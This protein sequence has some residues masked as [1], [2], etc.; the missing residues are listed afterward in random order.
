MKD[1]ILP[2][3]SVLMIT[4]NHAP[5]IAQALDSILAQERDFDL[6]IVI[7]EDCSTDHTRAIVL[8]YQRRYPDIVRPLLPSRNIGA[9]NNQIQVMEACRGR[10][11]AILEGD[12]YWTDASKLQRQ[13]AYLESHPTAA[14]VF[15]D[16][17][18]INEQGDVIEE[19]H[20]PAKYRHGFTLNEL[21]RE[22]CPPAL[23]VLYRNVIPTMPVEFRHVINGDY[24]LFA[25]LGQHGTIDYLAGSTAHYRR[26]TGGVWSLTSQER[27]FHS[28]LTTKL[29]MLSYFGPAH[30]KVIMQAVNWYYVYLLS[31]LWQQGRRTEFWSL[32]R[33]FLRVSVKTLNKELLSFTLRLLTGQLSAFIIVSN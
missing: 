15:T 13:V 24:V 10:Y 32:Y 31:L 6:E 33:T 8:D 16:C 5:Y 30:Q 26:H 14:L 11:V 17:V 2:M 29:A 7:G 23:T 27:Q 22:Y 12:D 9:M 18:V 3:V 28:N 4:Y 25:L 21:L 19:N 20:V 1:P